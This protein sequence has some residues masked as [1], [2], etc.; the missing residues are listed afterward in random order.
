MSKVTISMDYNQDY[1][2]LLS[3]LYARQ[4]H[5]SLESLRCIIVARIRNLEE[6]STEVR[7]LAEVKSMLDNALV[8]SD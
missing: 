5:D 3:I 8:F 4:M 7:F 2:D 1:D 6:D